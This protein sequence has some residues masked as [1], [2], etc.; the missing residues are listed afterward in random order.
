MKSHELIAKSL[1]D[2][3]IDWYID[4]NGHYLNHKK[5]GIQLWVVSGESHLK[6]KDFGVEMGALEKK[7]LWGSV[8]KCLDNILIR[9]CKKL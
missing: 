9:K 8:Q 7:S 1:E 4:D 2:N 3:S 5:S 6:I